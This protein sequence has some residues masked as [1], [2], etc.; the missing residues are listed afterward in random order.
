MSDT[1]TTVAELRDAWRRFVAARQWEPFHSPKNLVMALSAETAE[2][3]EHFLW[4]DND[5]SRRI[6]DDP[7]KLARVADE[8]ADVAGCLFTLCN[9]LGVDLSDAV[10]S[11]MARNEHKYPAEKYRGRHTAE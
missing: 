6:A 1:T 3:L 5:E 8:I 10:R 4:V 7:A 2:L 11:K 9:A